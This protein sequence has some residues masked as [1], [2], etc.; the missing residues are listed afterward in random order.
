MPKVEQLHELVLSLNYIKIQWNIASSD[1]YKWQPALK[2]I[3]MQYKKKKLV[4]YIIYMLGHNMIP[5]TSPF[6]TNATVI[7]CTS[8]LHKNRW[9][10]D[11]PLYGVYKKECF[12]CTPFQI[13]VNARNAHPLY[14][15]LSQRMYNNVN[16]TSPRQSRM[17]RSAT[18]QW[19]E[20]CPYILPY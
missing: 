1:D 6:R 13:Q 5:S 18:I 15:L 3:R 16:K 14:T 12:Q 8:T 20:S 4:S 11:L 17:Q 9:F 2:S 19:L 10:H 7:I